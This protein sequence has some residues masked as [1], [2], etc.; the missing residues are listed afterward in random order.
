M[1]EPQAATD[2][3]VGSGG[4]PAGL[5]EVPLEVDHQKSGQSHGDF[6][7]GL[8]VKEAKD[9]CTPVGTT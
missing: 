4:V 6:S 7:S 5:A 1:E 3:L 9:L 8:V 2:L